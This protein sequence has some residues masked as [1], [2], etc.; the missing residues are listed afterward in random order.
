M[1]PVINSLHAFKGVVDA[2]FSYKLDPDFE[3]KMALFKKCIDELE[4]HLPEHGLN[5]RISWKLHIVLF[6]LE[7]FCKEKKTGLGKYAEQAIESVHAK[8]TP[9]WKRYKVSKTHANHGDCLKKAVV[10]FSAIRR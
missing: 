6:H 9:T 1:E 7:P 8:F 4:V 5:L 3:K 10:N 2:M